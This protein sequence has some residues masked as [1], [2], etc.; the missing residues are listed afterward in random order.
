MNL[1]N[2]KAYAT[3]EEYKEEQ[4]NLI[5]ATMEEIKKDMLN[6]TQG[7]GYKFESYEIVSIGSLV[8]VQCFYHELDLY[9]NAV[10]YAVE[11]KSQFG[12][13]GK[14][15]TEKGFYPIWVAKH[16]PYAPITFEE[17]YND[18]EFINGLGDNAVI[19]RIIRK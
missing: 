8:E 13:N 11:V 2:K 3:K 19:K 1:F 14:E 16:N 5:K 18:Y 15:T 17:S 6:D 12:E 4:D 9:Y 10:G 7:L